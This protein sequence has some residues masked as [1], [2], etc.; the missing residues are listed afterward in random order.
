MTKTGNPKA[1]TEK[2][3]KA[4]KDN[5]KPARRKSPYRGQ[6]GKM[7]QETGNRLLS[8]PESLAENL[9]QLIRDKM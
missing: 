1:K 8:E 3:M 9:E 6:R 7:L 5:V 2:T 4:A